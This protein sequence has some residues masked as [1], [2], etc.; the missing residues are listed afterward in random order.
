VIWCRTKDR[1]AGTIDS[2][3]KWADNWFTFEETKAPNSAGTFRIRCPATNCV[4]ISRTERKPEVDGFELRGDGLPDYEDH[5]FQ[6]NFE[7]MEVE[8]VVYDLK[9]SKT[10]SA[11]PSVITQQKL[12]N[13]TSVTQTQ[14]FIYNED[15]TEETTFEHTFGLG[16]TVGQTFKIGS[17][18]IWSGETTVT[19]SFTHEWKWGTKNIVTT[20]WGINSPITVPA[21][22]TV[23]AV[24][25]ATQME[26]TVPFKIT[27]IAKN[28]GAKNITCGNY[29][30]VS[31]YDAATK[32]AETKTNS[33]ENRS[34]KDSDA[35]TRP[36]GGLFCQV[37]VSYQE[38]EPTDSYG[39]EEAYNEGQLDNG[40]RRAEQAED[41]FDLGS[42]ENGPYN[43]NQSG[44]F[45]K[46]D[47][48]V[49]SY[50]QCYNGS[51]N[52][53]YQQN[54]IRETDKRQSYQPEPILQS[55]LGP[56]PCEDDTSYQVSQ[57]S[58]VENQYS[59]PDYQGTGEPYSGD[60][61]A[62][63]S[64]TN[65]ESDPF[66]VETTEERAYSPDQDTNRSYEN[67]SFN[68][69]CGEDDDN[70]NR[71]NE[72]DQSSKPFY[73]DSR[74]SYNTYQP[75]YSQA[76]DQNYDDANTENEYGMTGREEQYED[77]EASSYDDQ[78]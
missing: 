12:E 74:A 47:Y 38:D 63:A 16:L 49:E 35:T 59:E 71:P 73:Q 50:S 52:L 68:R 10:T 3:G 77:V 65:Y 39:S 14:T 27:W 15:K 6:F 54:E 53:T 30:G 21:N 72:Y 28:S 18:P 57:E 60:Y 48:Q 75:S 13:K 31:Y 24:L 45:E 26:L 22:S 76:D 29:K 40:Q 51:Y 1:R 11:K 19:A 9:A 56:S 8:D 23:T 42:E 34:L 25:V 5:H 46:V 17:W 2:G 69:P 7:D 64:Y 4:L 55:T 78:A 66:N 67:D 43:D 20:K 62:Q 41:P 61:N 58:V 33:A 44:Q 70:Y 37:Q 32:I 36:N